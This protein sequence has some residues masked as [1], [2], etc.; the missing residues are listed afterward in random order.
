M[1]RT[2]ELDATCPRCGGRLARDN[3]SGRCGPCQAAERDRLTSPPAVPATFWDHGPI[4]QALTARHLGLAIRAYRCHPYHGRHPLPQET[5]ARW[6]GISQA[7]LS[8]LENGPAIVHLDRLTHWA[9]LLRI[10]AELLWFKLPMDQDDGGNTNYI[11]VARPNTRPAKRRSA[12]DVCAASPATKDNGLRRT[13]RDAHL[14]FVRSLR[15]ADRRVGGGHLYATVTAYLAD[16]AGPP[17][18]GRAAG[19]ASKTTFAAAASLNEI[20]GWMAH[21]AGA[22]APARRHL[23]L[24]LTLA[25]RSGDHQLV[26]Q[27]SAGLSHLA[28]HQGDAR[29]AI[30]HARNGLNHLQQAPS[31]GRLQARL[32]AIQARGLA[33]AGRPVEA[34]RALS[35]AEATLQVPITPA[36]EWLSPFDATS[37][38]IEAARCFLCIGDLSEAQ[39]RLQNVLVGRPADRVRSMAFAQLMLV[40]VLIGKGRIDEACAVTHRTLDEIAGLGSGVIIDQLQHA[41][42][43]F[44]SHAKA[45]TEVPPLLDRLHDA[46]RERSWIGTVG[47]LRVG[48]VGAGQLD[49]G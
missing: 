40:T 43:L 48:A 16:S 3:T 15:M 21:D 34:T 13:S 27:V 35:D 18:A 20:A 5:V 23:G 47:A 42:V 30:S 36:S 31:H 38:A 24:A 46:I 32:L 41:S 12:T 6:A 26:A 17:L 25:N 39:R 1:A 4:Q 2:P 33:I 37:L 22:D 49:G 14:H 7:Q 8:R 11:G 10:P 9:Q 45:C 28:C 29:N 19:R 44:T